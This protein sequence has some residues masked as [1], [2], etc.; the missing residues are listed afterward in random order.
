MGVHEIHRAIGRPGQRV[1]VAILEHD[2]RQLTQPWQPIARRLVDFMAV[3]TQR[4][5]DLLGEAPE[6]N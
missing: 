4:R 5:D 3:R 6:P 1:T 2:I